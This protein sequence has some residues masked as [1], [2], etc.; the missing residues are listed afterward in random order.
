MYTLLLFLHSLI[1]WFV[2]LSL[3]FAIISSYTGWRR[4]RNFSAK[5]NAVRHWTATIVHIQFMLGI[6]LYFISPIVRYFHNNFKEAVHLRE[7]R[8]FGMEHSLM[9]LIAVSII[10]VGSA[11]AKCRLTDKEKFKTIAIWYFIGLLFILSSI[12]W[13][14]SPLVNRPNFRGF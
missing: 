9:M 12:P 4:Q 14:F 8:F 1:R 10:S 6:A 11:K 13:S 5:D 7:I 2:L 3:L